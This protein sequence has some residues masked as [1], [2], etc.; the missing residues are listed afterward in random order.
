[1]WGSLV[2]TSRSFSRQALTLVA[3]QPEGPY[4]DPAEVAHHRHTLVRLMIAYAHAVRHHLRDTDPLPEIAS[5]L[6][7]A[8]LAQLSGQKNVPMSIVQLMAE[9]LQLW[10]QQLVHPLHLP[11]I[12]R[13]LSDLMNIQGGCERIKNT[14]FP[15]PYV[16]LSH[17]IVAFF[18]FLLPF[19]LIDTIGIF[20]PV[21]VFVVSHA[22]FG[23]DVI[24]EEVE[25]PFGTEAHK[26]PLHAISRTIEI[27][28]LQLLGE[29]KLP[30]PIQPVDKVL[31]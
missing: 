9:R 7:P 13:S 12:E 27:N 26:L 3:T 11:I 16:L 30:A 14:P 25:E 10:Q 18:C 22:F 23:L 21:V 17:R 15:V 19:G 24:G 1:M 29:A 31:L 20:T 8:D 2:N 5:Y 28:L 6:L 4:Y